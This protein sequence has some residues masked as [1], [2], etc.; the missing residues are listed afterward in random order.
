[1]A[2]IWDI[3]GL[4]MGYTRIRPERNPAEKGGA[5]GGIRRN[6]GGVGWG[7]GLCRLMAGWPSR[8]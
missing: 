7:A 4:Y 5:K 2:H 1:M 6:R 8:D 3:Y